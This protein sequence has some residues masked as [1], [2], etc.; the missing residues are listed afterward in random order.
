MT[1]LEIEE[2][3]NGI[4]KFSTKNGPEHTFRFM[5]LLGHPEDSFDTIH[6]AGSNGKGSVCAMLS[7]CLIE[8]G[9][10]T[11][12][13]TSP[14]LI[15]M[16]ERVMVDGEPISDED[17][18]DAFNETMETVEVMK[19]EGLDHPSFFEFLFGLA[20]VAFRRAGVKIAVI[21]T[22][23]GGRLDATNVIRRP[24]LTIITSISLEHTDILGN[25][26]TAIAGE[27]AGIIK[28]GVP[29]VFDGKHREVYDVIFKKV[30]EKKA[31]SY[32]V[33]PG[34]IEDLG[35]DENGNV[36]FKFDY[37]GFKEIIT[38]PFGA[39]YQRENGALVCQASEILAEKGYYSYDDMVEGLRKTKWKGRMQLVGEGVYVDGAHNVDG[40]RAFL[41]SLPEIGGEE[42]VLLFAMVKEKNYEEAISLLS[43]KGHFSKI[44]VT[45]IPGDR[46][47]PAEVSG[48]YFIDNNAGD[49]HIIKD[50]REAYKEALKLK[51]DKTL[52]CTGSLYF[53]GSIL[54]LMEE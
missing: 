27:K 29:V 9:N 23:L 49:V 15:R 1:Y 12:L 5:E 19:K 10:R 52:F 17:F 21:E 18:V 54:E 41:Q 22:G 7:S 53:V 13:F 48:Q 40:I 42:P 24:I 37:F 34:D 51:G 47:L 6:V 39:D 35:R 11:G 45:E 43:E 26:L 31:L 3:I 2:Y 32:P 25:T 8:G 28:E 30:M 14:H 44:I 50:Y 16:S 36:R 20:M 38:L 4:P 33:Y 46:C